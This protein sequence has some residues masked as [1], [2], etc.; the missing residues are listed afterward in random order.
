MIDEL[1]EGMMLMQQKLDRQ[2]KSIA[3]LQAR[4]A[5]LKNVNAE[6][7]GTLAGLS[8]VREVRQPSLT[9][10]LQSL[11][12]RKT[13]TLASCAHAVGGHPGPRDGGAQGQGYRSGG[14]AC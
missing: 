7:E 14:H 1:R 9:T 13:L 5:Y 6:L 3:D 11:W 12:T 4:S 8:S 10:R 2:L